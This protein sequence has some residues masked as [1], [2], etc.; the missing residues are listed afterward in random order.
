LIRQATVLAMK[1]LRLLLRDRAAAFFTFVFPLAIALFFG[2][3]FSGT[4]SEPLKV[5]A[6]VERPSPQADAF[7]KALGD[8]GGFSLTVVDDRP[9]GELAVRRGQAAAMVVVPEAYA[10]GLDSV[11]SGGGAELALVVDPSRRAEGAML[12]GKIHE[13][14]FR[15]V[16]S[17]MSDPEQFGRMLDRAEKSLEASDLPLTDRI[18]VRTALAR[19]RAMSSK[20]RE[21][22]AQAGA[23]EGGLAG[24]RPVKVSVGE[25][26]MQPGIPANSFAISFT[27]GLA[28]ALFGAVLAF[29]SGIAEERQRGTLVRLLVSPMRPVT[30]L[31]GKALGCFVACLATEWLL[32]LVGVAFFGVRVS[33]WPLLALCSAATAFGFCGVMMM[34]AGGFRTQGGAQGAGRAVLL[35]LTMVGGGTVPLVFMPP[36]LRLASN[37]SPFKWAVLVAEGCTWR[38]W[39]MA[40][41]WL[42]LAALVAVGAAGL[43]IG[44]VMVRRAL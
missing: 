39:G 1:D 37:A 30:I 35:V 21:G 15:T 12:V 27:Q 13:V 25:L 10:E 18:A 34:L 36:F 28:W 44:A 4:T 24:W 40:E 31:V 20:P 22:A 38:S 19:A 3:V 33:S 42:P 43:A 14:A 9:A 23:G 41:L 11:F 32:V 17:S 2:Y 6:F 7:V 16:F 8:D 26:E 29:G 5:V